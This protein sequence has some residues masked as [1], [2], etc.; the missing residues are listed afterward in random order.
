MTSTIA[1]DGQAAAAT[2]SVDFVDVVAPVIGHLRLRVA[3]QGSGPPLLLIM[4]LGGGIDMWRPLVDSL[5]GVHTIAVDGPGVGESTTPLRPLSM[6]ELAEVYSCLIR[7]LDLESTSVLGFSFGGAV[8]Q[9][10]ALSSPALVDRL[11][12]T[13]TGPGLGG[14][15][16]QPLALAELCT[17]WR[18]YSPERLRQVAPIV[19]GGRTARDPEA[20]RS[21][22]QE[23]MH[24][25]PT[26][27]GYMWQLAALAGWSSMPFLQRISVPTLVLTGDED[28]VFPVANA[29]LLA[30]AIPGAELEV[31]RGGGHLFVLDSAP[32]VAPIISRF[33]E[34]AGG[35]APAAGDAHA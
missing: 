25:G 28:P 1:G 2:R 15:P 20:L 13:A 30:R 17:P 16:G 22:A 29:R 14:L 8:A 4:G 26:Y 5:V 31:I 9:Q 19:Y 12:L 24:A 7:A 33:L 23:R 32:E 27:L 6:L 34:R 18:Y 35:R 11:V 10:L 21:R 3:R